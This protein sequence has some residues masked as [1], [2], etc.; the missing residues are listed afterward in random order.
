MNWKHMDTI[1]LNGLYVAQRMIL[2]EC[3]AFFLLDELG[4]SDVIRVLSSIFSFFAT[5]V[6]DPII[7]ENACYV[8]SMFHMIQNKN[9]IVFW[10]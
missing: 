4:K 7:Q 10:R 8:Y 9:T 3:C 1:I 2:H 6:I 5:I